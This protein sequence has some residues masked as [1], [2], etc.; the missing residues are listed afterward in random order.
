MTFVTTSLV[1]NETISLLQSRGF[2]SAAL[3]FLEGIRRGE[4]QI[5][6][7]DAALQREAWDLFGQWVGS[8]ASA[9]DCVS[10]A[11][12]KREGIRKAFTFDSHFRA[13]GFEILEV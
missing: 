1:I 7:P 9:V 10:F 5:L 12:M 6:Y 4:A 11:V 13:A 8:G 2:L 3:Q